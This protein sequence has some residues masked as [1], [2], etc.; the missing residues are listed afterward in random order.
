MEWS[1]DNSL[2][3]VEYCLNEAQ[4]LIR[5]LQCCLDNKRNRKWRS[6]FA[7]LAGD[8]QAMGL[9]AFY[10]WRRRARRQM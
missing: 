6:A 8:D 5:Q 10:I 1:T 9:L 2:V 4:V 3:T 7:A